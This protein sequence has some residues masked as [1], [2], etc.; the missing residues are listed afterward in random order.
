MHRLLRLRQEVWRILAMTGMF[1]FLLTASVFLFADEPPK[2]DIFQS[3]IQRPVAGGQPV[4]GQPVNVALQGISISSKGSFAVINGIV[5][6]EGEEKSGIKAVKIR[7]REVD[8][9]VSGVSRTLQM[10][11]YEGAA[12]KGPKP[13][14]PKSEEDLPEEGLEET[15]QEES[16]AKDSEPSVGL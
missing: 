12:G 15:V 9:E 1:S 2:R 6:H 8:I 10:V 3:S 11:V 4:A 7:R 5:L 14:T 16:L 13:E